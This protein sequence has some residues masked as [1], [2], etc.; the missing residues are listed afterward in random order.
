[1]NTRKKIAIYFFV[2]FGLCFM[3]ATG[4][5][6]YVNALVSKDSN[7]I[8]RQTYLAKYDLS[9]IN[10]DD[11]DSELDRIEKEVL[12][13]EINLYVNHEEKTFKLYEIGMELDKES[14]KK[15]LLGYESSQDYYDRY[16]KKSK[17]E[18]DIKVYE[19]RYVLNEEKLNKFLEELRDNTKIVPAKGSLVMNKETRE[20]S[21][22]GEITGYELN[23]EESYKILMDSINN[24]MYS[25]KVTLSGNNSH[26]EDI[27]KT[28][29]KKIGSASSKFIP[30]TS[31]VTN[32]EVASSRID[33][34]I[35]M[36]GE[37]FSY[38]NHTGP[39]V[40]AG[41]YGYVYYSGVKANGVCQVAST[42]YDAELVSNLTTITRYSHPD[43]PKYV[44]GALDATVSQGDWIADFKF[45]NTLDYPVYISAYVSGDTITVDMW[46]NEN[47]LNGEEIK[48]RSEQVGYGS[49]NAYRE[50]YKDG[51]LVW[52]EYLNHSWY[53]T[54]VDELY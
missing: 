33:G 42:L 48:L 21:Y 25:K 6:L 3:Y 12:S 46:S 4:R 31:R 16:I 39:Y 34:V 50:H 22:E 14:I 15:E 7:K 52:D 40:G 9:L 27:N 20:L 17:N 13:D 36:P 35:L 38:Y 47:A 30:G 32:L 28:I 45:K 19:L 37:V 8:E 26:E 43:R 29:N 53:Y 49:Y 23:I 11:I 18:Y 10:Y 5:S 54:E 51:N 41:S 1:M 2:L 44:P 24:G